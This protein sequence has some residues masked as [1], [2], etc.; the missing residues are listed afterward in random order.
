MSIQAAALRT[1][2]ATVAIVELWALGWVWYCGLVRRRGRALRVAVALLVAE[3]VALVIGRGNC[4]L[5]P[6]QSR[7]GDPVPLFELVLPPRAAKAAIPILFGVAVAGLALAAARSP[8]TTRPSSALTSGEDDDLAALSDQARPCD[9]RA[10][11]PGAF[12]AA[13]PDLLAREA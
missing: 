1:A 13:A 9:R 6:L 2:H 8:V 11:L 12:R 5:G 10:Q 4:P 7:L 3:G